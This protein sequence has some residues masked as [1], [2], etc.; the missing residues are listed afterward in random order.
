MLVPQ[1]TMTEDMRK[2]M[3]HHP[4][5]PGFVDYL[6]L[7]FTTSTAFSP[8]D[9]PVLSHWAKIMMILQSAISLG[10]VVLLAARAVN[11]L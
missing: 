1:M 11:I 7:A 2:Q 5:R 8:T 10:A 4:W 3:G 9:V 6:F